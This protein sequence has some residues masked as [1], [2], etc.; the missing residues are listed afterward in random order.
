M[1][2]ICGFRSRFGKRSTGGGTQKKI[3]KRN[4]QYKTVFTR[5]LKGGRDP[6]LSHAEKYL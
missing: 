6:F 1:D 2:E 5:F 3:S 4:K